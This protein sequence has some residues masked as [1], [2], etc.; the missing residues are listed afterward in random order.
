MK[1]KTWYHFILTFRSNG[2]ITMYMNE[3]IIQHKTV[4]S[5]PTNKAVPDVERTNVYVGKSNM[6]GDDPSDII[7]DEFVVYDYLATAS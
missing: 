2:T 3:K 7:L 1:L 5:N 4:V 6:S